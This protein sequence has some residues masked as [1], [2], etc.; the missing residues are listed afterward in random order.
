M[1]PIRQIDQNDR[2]CLVC[3]LCSILE[4]E[5]TKDVP[6]G[7]KHYIE[8]IQNWLPPLY[9]LVYVEV[10]PSKVWAPDGTYCVVTG[11]CRNADSDRHAVV[12]QW[13]DGDLKIVF[14]PNPRC[15]YGSHTLVTMDGVI[16]IR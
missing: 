6:E 5:V 11:V 8:D 2:T 7:G 14:D 16:I 3:C 1:I 12:G 9:S 4:I 13:V 10:H 15:P